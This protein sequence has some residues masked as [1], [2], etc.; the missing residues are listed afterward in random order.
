MAVSRR[1]RPQQLKV[2]PPQFFL[3]STGIQTA[4]TMRLLSMPS[5]PN[6]NIPSGLPLIADIGVRQLRR[7]N[8]RAPVGVTP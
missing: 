5:S 6:S 2:S 7:Q 3:T 1:C 8:A 4:L